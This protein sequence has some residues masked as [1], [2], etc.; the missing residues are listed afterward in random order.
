[1][2]VKSKAELRQEA[3]VMRQHILLTAAA[4]CTELELV[5]HRLRK[6]LDAA[7]AKQINA[8]AEYDNLKRQFGIA[9]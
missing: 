8:K 3:A 4:R 7:T 5:V 1:M 9:G 6:E 2:K